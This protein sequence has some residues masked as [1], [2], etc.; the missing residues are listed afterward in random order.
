MYVQ[1]LYFPLMCMQ[2][3]CHEGGGLREQLEN[4]FSKKI[5]RNLWYRKYEEAKDASVLG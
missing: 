3:R 1:L 2:W 5:L 4:N